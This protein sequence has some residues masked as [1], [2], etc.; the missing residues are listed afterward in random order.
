MRRTPRR[1]PGASILLL[2]A[3]GFLLAAAGSASLGEEGNYEEGNYEEEDF[4]EENFPVELLGYEIALEVEP[5]TRTI[6]GVVTV[7]VVALEK[8]VST[9]PFSLNVRLKIES[10]TEGEEAVEFIEGVRIAEGRAVALTPDPPLK[11]GKPRRFTFRYAG[12]GVDPGAED[13]DWM[14]ILLVRPDEIRM[15]HQAQWYPIVPRDGRADSTLLAPV[16][17]S[18]T[19]PVG[20][21][22]VGPGSWEGRK[23]QET[24][25]R[26]SWSS[27]TPCA[28]SILAGRYEV[29]ELKAGTR[30]LRVL[31]FPDHVESAEQWVEEAAPA[32]KFYERWLGRAKGAHHGIAEM[33]VRN[34]ERSH[35]YE[36]HGFSVFDGDLLVG[37]PV[38]HPVDRRWAAHEAAHLWWG[39]LVGATGPGERFLTESLAEFSALLFLQE[40]Y[41]E[42]IAG[43]AALGSI[44]HYLEGHG[45][46]EEETSLATAVFTSPRYDRVVYAKGAMALR[47]L[48]FWLGTKDFDEGLK[49]YLKRFRG[50]KKAPRLA[51]FLDAMR[52]KGG[53]DVDRWAEEWL[54]RPGAPH[55][56]VDYSVVGELGGSTTVSV[57]LTQRGELYTNPVEVDILMASGA[58]QRIRFEPREA[59]A[60]QIVI[61]RDLVDS[62]LIDP[63]VR[64]L[65]LDRR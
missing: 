27:R 4:E 28:A 23:K 32:V 31:S 64:V 42:G 22:S 18:L 53:D 2:L 6:T 52:S 19:L 37:H 55:Y 45:D 44:E 58:Y 50:G 60:L 40:V 9:L 29:R 16:E 65:S 26:H 51:D 62:L 10:V 14:G 35:G 30:R 57:T 5:E 34:R 59:E 56:T 24:R 20:M 49:L 11:R 61:V 17:V 8:G 41:G 39:G 54:L 43:E 36:A 48:R 13:A 15:H 1:A 63:R 25:E 33:R 12:G 47:T 3:S 21:E 46:H 38:D 7:E